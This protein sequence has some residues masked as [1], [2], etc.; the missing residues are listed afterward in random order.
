MELEALV[1][2]AIYSVRMMRLARWMSKHLTDDYERRVVGRMVLVFAPI[3]I[4]CAFALLNR[5]PGLT[6]SDR[7]QLREG[8]REL[9]G[10]FEGFYDRIR[11]DF[12]A[13][14]D[15]IPL[16]LAIEAW[17]EIDSDTL[18]WFCTA[19]D[20]SI[21]DIVGRHSLIAGSVRD[22]PDMTDQELARKLAVLREDAGEVRFSTDALSMTRG[23][24]GIVPVHEVQDSAGVLMS[25]SQSLRICLRIN[26]LARGR[27]ASHLLLKTMF[28]ID[29]M[30][31]VDGVYGEPV[32][33]SSKR[34]ASFLAILEEGAFGGA[35]SLRQSLR[36]ADLAAIRAV[37]A[38]R[39]RACAHL[40]PAF[41][42]RQLQDMVLDLD[43]SVIFDRVLNPTAAA[44]HN[45]CAE[46]IRT[47]WLLM[48]EPSFAGLR[49]AS[50][51][52]VRSFDRDN[53]PDKDG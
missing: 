29:T 3:Y 19:V 12:A 16:D 1:D 33:A 10:D 15:A 47:H 4:G 51:P 11:H 50:T 26:D 44:L 31:L 34:S 30:N 17:N 45:A 32:G 49:P 27:L 43:D 40:D 42:L 21:A 18:A 20:E 25:V 28:V 37:R 14:R 9:R 46:D 39:N 2:K 13:H 22:F 35:A 36:E 38:V 41:S 53:P 24:I 8:T 52:G 7:R 48:D 23:H 5:R 6:E